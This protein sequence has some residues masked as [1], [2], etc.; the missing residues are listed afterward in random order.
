MNAAAEIE[1]S[2]HVARPRERSVLWPYVFSIAI[3]G[4]D[5][6][7]S[8]AGAGAALQG[9]LL[10]LYIGCFT[11]ILMAGAKR[12]LGFGP[13]WV[14]LLAVCL[15]MIDSATVGLINDQPLYSIAVNLV[16]VFLYVA[17]SGMTYI[18]LSM[19][20]HTKPSF[21]DGLRLACLASGILHL[22]AVSASRGPIDLSTS[23]FEVLSG[24]V[25]PS[26]GILAV[27]LAQR[28]SKLDILVV[29]LN[30]AIALLSVTRTLVIALAVQLATMFISRPSIIFRRATLKGVAIFGLIMLAIVATD[31]AAETG[32]TAR[33]M[34]RL[35]LSHKLGT[36]PS[37]LSRIAETHFMWDRF[38][39]SLETMVFGN[40]LAA[41]TS[42]VGREQARTQLL[43]GRDDKNQL[44]S[45]GIGH[46]NYVGILYVAGLLGGGGLL[47]IQ[48]LNA[49]QSVTLIRDLQRRTSL[50]RA[51]DA[52][53]GIWGGLIVLGML[54]LG[55]LAG[56]FQDRDECL[57]LGVGT[58]MLYWARELVRTTT[59]N[60]GA[61]AA[62]RAG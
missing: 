16:P 55:F 42:A 19:T 40:G 11:W 21:L 4:L 25:V 52:H 32:L 29:L 44:H 3:W 59:G 38:D 37:G 47:L 5:F 58:G 49:I 56:T 30:L 17:T 34:E 48:F 6:R 50:F 1:R 27:G 20:R 51:G 61:N 13:V 31:Y 22:L 12:G 10:A 15:F 8:T 33:W 2:A 46:E 60:S 57:W 39:A 36:D 26:L 35:F 43:V 14:L 23:R 9:L 53:V 45:I 41:V 18:T 62:D 24:S 7:A 28:L 54:T